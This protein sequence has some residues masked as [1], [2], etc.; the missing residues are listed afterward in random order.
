MS[1]QYMPGGPLLDIAVITGHLEE[2]QLPHFACIG[3]DPTLV[4]KIAVVHIED[5]DMSVSVPATVT[6]SHVK[7]LHPTFSPLAVILHLFG[8]KWK[9]HGQLLL[10]KTSKAFLTLHIYLGLRSS[11]VEQIMK[12]ENKKGYSKIEVTYPPRPLTM[13]GWFSLETDCSEAEIIPEKIQLKDMDTPPD[14]F[15]VYVQDAD[16]DRIL[17][18]LTGAEE[19]GVVWTQPLRKGDYQ[20]V[21]QQSGGESFVDRHKEQLIQRVYSVGPILDRLYSKKVLTPE[22]CNKV[23][24]EATPQ[25]RMRALISGPLRA[26]GDVAKEEFYQVL[27]E[28]EPLLVRDLEEV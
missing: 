17:L 26:G 1:M 3:H 14:F 11:A 20:T 15:E 13:D 24:A 16:Y 25:D 19:N 8:W 2:V 12:E 28:M 4:D 9:V 22:A 27:R 23:T 18:E 7:V 5:S 10:Y 21:S 6:A